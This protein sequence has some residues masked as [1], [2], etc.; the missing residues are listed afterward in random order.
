MRVVIRQ[1]TMQGCCDRL[2]YNLRGW[3]VRFPSGR[4]VAVSSFGRALNEAGIGSEEWLKELQNKI[5]KD[6]LHESP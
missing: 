5:Y 4:E 1:C 3:T 6:F 2:A